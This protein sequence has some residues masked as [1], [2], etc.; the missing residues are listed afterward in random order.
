MPGKLTGLKR[1]THFS[2][3][4]PAQLHPAVLKKVGLDQ[5]LWL[6]VING[7][8]TVL[9]SLGQ[10]RNPGPGSSSVQLH[11]TQN[12]RSSSLQQTEATE[13]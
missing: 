13:S 6:I 1:G 9:C 4:V 8:V 10:G 12:W 7:E 5:R 2:S 11:P 3:L